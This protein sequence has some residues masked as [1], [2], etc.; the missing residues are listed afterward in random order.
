M[1]PQ[2]TILILAK[3][4]SSTA[5]FHESGVQT[6]LDDQ[7][8]TSQMK[9]PIYSI[10]GP[11]SGRLSIVL[12]PRGGDWLPTEIEFWRTHNLDHIVSLL[13]PA[14]E[15]ELD[16]AS[17][18][19][20]VTGAGMAFTRIRV[21]DRGVPKSTEWFRGQIIPIHLSLAQGQSVGIHCRQSIGRASLLCAC[22][23]VLSGSKPSEAFQQIH[24]AR[25]CAVPDTS[26]QT[27]WVNR[28]A[29]EGANRP[30]SC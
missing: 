9:S 28:F 4:H 21:Q 12:R 15:L 26:E 14:E 5:G 8:H 1:V 24:H 13:A 29:R 2:S 16:L 7:D 30:G 11:W 27:E 25:G 18:E 23:L 22:L 6:R 17:E 20:L 3:L 19:S 10:P